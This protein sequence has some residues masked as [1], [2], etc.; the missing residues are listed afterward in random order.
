MSIPSR[1]LILWL[2]VSFIYLTN[3]FTR[4][5]PEYIHH[6]C[7]NAT[8]YTRNS[9]YQRNLITAFSALPSTNSGLGFF[10]S[11]SGQGIDRVNSV[12]LCRGDINLDM[13]LSC[14]NSS[15]V[16]LQQLCPNQKEAIVY[17][18]YCSLRYSNQTISGNVNT[19]RGT[20]WLMW[21]FRNATN[22]DQFN[23][24]LRPL[25]IELRADAAAGG[26]LKKFA[27]G[28]RTGPD[29]TTIYGLVQC[30]PDLS[31]LEC[32]DCLEDAVNRFGLRYSGSVGG[33]T[34]KPTCN[35]RYEIYRFFNVSTL[36]ITPPPSSSPA[37]PTSLASPPVSASSSPGKSSST[38]VTI[39]V[40]ISIVTV[41]LIIIS[42]CIFVRRIK[43][44]ENL[45]TET[46]ETETMDI[47]NAES[48]QYTFSLVKA[49]TN[50]F[51]EDNKLGKG[52]FGAVYKGT[53]GN[54]Q[55]IAVKRL[56]RDS[57]QGDV[58]FKNEVLLVAK[59]QH[60]NLVRLLG[61]SIEGSER[62]LIYEYLPNASLDQFIFD[63]TKCTLL[64][65]EKRY[66]IIKG[67]AKG[68]LY[69]HEDSRL[70]II[71]RDL[72]A[73]NVL[74]D[75]EMNAKIADFGMARL[76]KPEETQGDTSRIVGTY[77]YM[78]PEYAMHGQFSVKSDVF[79]F[80]VLVLETITGQKNQCFHKGESVEDLL[81]FAWKNWR[82][83]TVID[84][85][86]PTLR[87]GSGSLHD[88]IRSIHIGLLCV[89]ENVANRPTMASAVLMLNS[90]S[91]TIPVPSEPA[92]FMHS[93]IDPEMPLFH[94]Y[95]SSTSSG[96][97]GK[98]SIPKS[99][100]FSVNDVSISEI[101]PR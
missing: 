78:A 37:P 31:S 66:K 57:G 8:N 46:T 11:S 100:E 90:F 64:D 21:N 89:Q 101:I 53:L 92:F 16:N 72:K 68:L 6:V 39:I 77:G 54:G 52:G 12:A 23:G 9:T 87:T 34:L 91:L 1:T 24:D 26:S 86:D 79:S 32:S 65:W 19:P 62:L 35:F 36:V 70:R 20:T 80:G 29:F 28:N 4:A 47:T 22:K 81:S 95:S 75:A 56:A 94:Q 60:R 96:G 7:E 59:L 33:R 49:A 10:N 93:K 45:S 88:I 42:I 71:H 55:E 50:N 17:Y 25:L 76:F 84:I 30:N 14:L 98:S 44:R 5:Q 69:L 83:K 67:V 61:F 51:S 74:L 15:I 38:T 2:T 18:D 99:S 13:C 85:I 82:N 48:L 97:I 40:T 41:V 43:R 3:T 73:S 58:E 63:K 27:S